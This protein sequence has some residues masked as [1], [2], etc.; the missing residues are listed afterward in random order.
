MKTILKKVAGSDAGRVKVLQLFNSLYVETTS[1]G[2]G[3]DHSLSSI[4]IKA[5]FLT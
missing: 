2:V 3:K 4:E 1:L 5:V